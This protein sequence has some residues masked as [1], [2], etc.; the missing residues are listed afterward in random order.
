MK[1]PVCDSADSKV[2]DSRP[3]KDGN[4]IWRR[5]ECISCSNRF[6]TYERLEEFYPFIIKKDGRREPFDRQ[7]I[8]AGLQ[9]ACEKRPISID[10]LENVVKDIER[11]LRECNEKEIPSRLVGEKVIRALAALDKIAY[12]RFASVYR[13]FKDV[14][15]FIKEVKD[16]DS[17]K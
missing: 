4:V 17:G 16:L 11:F 10:T 12:V 9:K 1:C 8:L 13:E 14:D 2:I 5:R 6:T 7:K 3:I 15:Q